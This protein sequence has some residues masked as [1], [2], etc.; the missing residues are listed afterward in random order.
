[1]A[2]SW[3]I[4]NLEKQEVDLKAWVVQ[5]LPHIYKLQNQGGMHIIDSQA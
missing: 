1:M 2:R 5:S 3:H 4:K